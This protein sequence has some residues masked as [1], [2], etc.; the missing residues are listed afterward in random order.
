MFFRKKDD[1]TQQDEFAKMRSELMEHCTESYKKTCVQEF[2]D[3][4]EAAITSL[5]D[6]THFDESHVNQA[7]TNVDQALI[8]VQRQLENI[9]KMS[10]GNIKQLYYQ[11]FHRWHPLG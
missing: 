5:R 8:V 4:A 9:S 6:G 2:D 1:L 11:T 10:D 7:Q 3:F